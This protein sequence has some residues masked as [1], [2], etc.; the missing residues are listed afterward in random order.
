MN[1]S[2]R[3]IPEMTS[4]KV[5]VQENKMASKKVSVKKAKANKKANNATV[6]KSE[7]VIKLV[8]KITEEDAVKII[9][10]SGVL[11]PEG[12]SGFKR[13]SLSGD[14]WKDVTV[15]SRSRKKGP[16]FSPEFSVAEFT[17]D[18]QGYKEQCKTWNMVRKAYCNT[19]YN[20]MASQEE[21][22][23]MLLSKLAQ[24]LGGEPEKIQSELQD[25]AKT[26]GKEVFSK[27]EKQISEAYLEQMQAHRKMVILQKLMGAAYKLLDNNLVDV[28]TAVPGVSFSKTETAVPCDEPYRTQNFVRSHVMD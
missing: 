28:V 18:N 19:E 26:L 15:A 14:E 9:K 25:M 3:N 8:P 5:S 10:D 13:D 20:K 24:L 16:Q 12:K 21:L 1:D 7:P 11:T 6:K 17:K 23:N 4:K 27:L 2:L 22:D